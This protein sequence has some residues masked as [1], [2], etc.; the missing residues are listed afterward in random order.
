MS[1][2][3]PIKHEKYKSF[4]AFWPYYLSE[5]QLI[6][7]RALHY[8]GTV[9]SASLL[10]YLMVTQQWSWLPM[11]LITGYGPAWIGHFFIEKNRPAT[12]TYPWWSLLGDYKM[13]YLALK[14]DVRSEL[15]R[16]L[17][18]DSAFK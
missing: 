14:G 5:H 11:V 8:T 1:T 13:F 15:S 17:G 12:F 16:F 10:I 18:S 7:C 3:D 2:E 4:E 9:S 6:T